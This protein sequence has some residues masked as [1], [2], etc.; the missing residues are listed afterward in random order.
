M[1]HRWRP[2]SIAC[3]ALGM[4]AALALGCSGFVGHRATGGGA[5][6]GGGNTTGGPGGTGTSTTGQ[7]GAGGTGMITPGVFAP[8]GTRLR[9]LTSLEYRNSVV[10]LL[11][12]GTQ[13]TVELEK[14]TSYN[15]LTAVAASTIALSAT[16]TEQLETSALAL[17]SAL[18]KDTARRTKVVGCTPT[19]AA[20]E[21]CM[22][23]FVTNF[24]RRAFRR[25]LTTDEITQYAA[26]G[27]TAMTTLSDFWGGVEYVVAG[28]LQSPGFI[29]R[30]E[31]GATDPAAPAGAR[32]LGGYE[33]AAR[34]SYFLWGS[35]PDDALLTA[36]NDNSLVTAAGLTTQIERLRASPRVQDSLVEVFSQVLRLGEVDALS[37]SPTLFPAAASVTLGASMRGETQ[38]LLRNLLG[39]DGDYRELFTTTQTFVNAELASLYGVPAPSGTGLVA[40]ALPASGPRGG[41]LGH[42]SFLALNAHPDGTSPTLRGKFIVETLLCRSIPPP[43]NDVITEIPEADKAKT[44]RDQL[45]VHQ[46][47]NTCAV[48]HTLMDPIGLALEHFD[49]IGAYR[50]T[51]RGMPLDVTGTVSGKSF[52]GARELGQLLANGLVTADGHSQTA[53]CV[54][55]NL[56]RV[57]TG[58]LEHAGDA[59]VVTSV[60]TAFA[61]D[62]YRLSTALAK[63]AASDS[64]R[65]VGEPQ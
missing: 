62:T 11:G 37:Q 8:A 27:K 49:A 42:A 22:R 1:I 3:S 31:I 51:D 55:R 2:K 29:Y 61:G 44:K 14:D 19:G 46:T 43:P 16:L 47:L 15:N 54:V 56:L 38:A 18:V 52:N 10:D 23:T 34:L 9:R 30:T 59:P 21:A 17:A 40:T 13:V 60:T 33:L 20:D 36:A 28:F 32:A 5:T 58:R 24:G 7:G 57:A 39:R 50:D 64:F 35:T 45:R 6:S 26:L 4:T 63:V 53:E 12:A 41:L 25:P 65:F 48:C